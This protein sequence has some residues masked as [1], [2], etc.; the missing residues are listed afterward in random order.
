MS[1]EMSLQFALAPLGSG[2]LKQRDRLGV[3]RGGQ[4]EGEW[5][6]RREMGREKQRH[7]YY[8]SPS[9]NVPNAVT[10][11]PVTPPGGQPPAGKA[12]EAKRINGIPG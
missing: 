10:D 4:G 6:N 8:T 11:K 1:Y 9:P 12:L 2:F 7:R 3:G 5:R